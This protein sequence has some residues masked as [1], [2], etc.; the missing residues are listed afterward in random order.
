ME[1]M[2]EWFVMTLT[3]ANNIITKGAEIEADTI[4]LEAEILKLVDAKIGQ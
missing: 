1:I 2:E 3:K 4:A